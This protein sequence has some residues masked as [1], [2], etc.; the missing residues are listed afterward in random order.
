[1]TLIGVPTQTAP[2]RTIEGLFVRHQEGLRRWALGLTGSVDVAEDVVQEAFAALQANLDRV[3]QPEAYLRQ[4]TLNAA[5]RVMRGRYR[6]PITVPVDGAGQPVS[7]DFDR[8]TWVA[9]QKLPSEQRLVV[10][11]RYRDDLPLAEIAT[12][13]NRSEASVKSLLHRSL[14]TLRKDLA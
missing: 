7:I 8:D 6:A 5:R 2:T 13:L 11:L 12:A 9:L 1:V 3:E 14:K 10:V 4:V